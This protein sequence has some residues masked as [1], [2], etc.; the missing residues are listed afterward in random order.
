ML[1]SN[2]TLIIIFGVLVLLIIVLIAVAIMAL[3]TKPQ[4]DLPVQTQFT[5][6]ARVM[7]SP[8]KQDRPSSA[9]SEQ[10]EEIVKVKLKQHGNLADVHIDFGTVSDG[11]I[12]VWVDGQQFD[13]PEDI[14]DERIRQVIQE[15]VAEFNAS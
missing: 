8:G 13:N 2:P 10:I 6:N 15:A 4:D 14:P 12:D 5:P 1:G 7:D 3:N 9:I 11:T